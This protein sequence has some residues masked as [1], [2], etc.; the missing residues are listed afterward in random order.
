MTTDERRASE[1][2]LV[3][4][5]RGAWWAHALLTLTIACALLLAA[6]HERRACELVDCSAV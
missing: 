1:I 6:A 3:A 5:V 4:V 2:A